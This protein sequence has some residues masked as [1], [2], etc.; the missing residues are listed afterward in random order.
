M[1]TKTGLFTAALSATAFVTTSRS[2]RV[3]PLA[4]AIGLSLFATGSHAAV[5]ASLTFTTPSGTVANNVDIPVW[6]TLTLDSSSDALTTDAVG[7]VTSGLSAADIAALNGNSTDVI[8][9]NAFQC[10]D[11]FT[12]CFSGSPYGFDFNYA[13]PSLIGARN[14]NLAPGSSS[15]WLFGVFHPQAGGATPGTYSFFNAIF[16]FEYF[17]PVT[18]VHYASNIASTC[19]SSSPACAFT[20]T[21]TGSVGGGVPEPATWALMIAGFGLVGTSLRR[22]R[23]FA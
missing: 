9:N 12:N 17:D 3:A 21:I 5:N 11:T 7:H 23:A 1:G 14:L 8:V 4:A 13:S 20:R 2:L 22:R 19:A 16:E 10:G 18:S 15:S 6:L